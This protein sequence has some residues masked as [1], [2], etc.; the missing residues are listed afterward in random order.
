MSNVQGR[1]IEMIEQQQKQEKENSAPWFVGEQLKDICKREPHSAELLIHDFTIPDMSL[2]NAEKQ[3]KA[4]ADKN[5]TGNCA[6]VPPPVAEGI[7]R[8]FYG[9]QASEGMGSIP[10]P[11]PSGSGLALDLT[12]YL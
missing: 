9:L 8:K 2:A 1:A 7:L 10:V 11:K 4:W 3:I 5:K 6:F 12:D